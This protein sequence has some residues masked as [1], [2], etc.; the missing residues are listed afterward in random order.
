MA[1]GVSVTALAYKF[2]KMERNIRASGSIIRHMEKARS[3]M[4]MVTIT[5][6]NFVTINLM[7]TVY[8]TALMARCTRESGLTISSMEQGKRTGLTARAT[9]VTIWRVAA[10]VL[11]LTNGLM[12]ILIVENGP[13][14]L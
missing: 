7:A 12:A 11:A 4:Q 2:G 1:R 13:T 6:A 3:G 9:S 5:K 14:T 8:F 10:M